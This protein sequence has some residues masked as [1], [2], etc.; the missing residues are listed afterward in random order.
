MLPRG[1]RTF[2]AL[3]L[4]WAAFR[5]AEAR[6]GSR[7]VA[8]GREEVLSM[9][10]RV[11]IRTVGPK[12]QA[13]AVTYHLMQGTMQDVHDSLGNIDSILRRIES[14]VQWDVGVSF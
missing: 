3:A 9:Y 11:G 7:I 12:F 13:G 2:L 14:E 8:I 6:G 10:S 1:R 4:M 5:W